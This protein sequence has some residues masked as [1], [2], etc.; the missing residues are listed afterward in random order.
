MQLRSVLVIPLGLLLGALRLLLCT[1]ASSAQHSSRQHSQHAGEQGVHMTSPS[2]HTAAPAP[3]HAR[4]AASPRRQ[5][6]PTTV[7]KRRKRAKI[8][9][10][11]ANATNAHNN[12]Q[13]PCLPWGLL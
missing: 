6:R 12:C 13:A 4:S 8:M 1:A 5:G 7:E 2:S 9:F 3:R 11:M 10:C